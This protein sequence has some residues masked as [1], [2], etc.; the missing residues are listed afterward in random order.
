MLQKI[1]R[2]PASRFLGL[3]LILSSFAF[4]GSPVFA[5]GVRGSR[6]WPITYTL[7]TTNVTSN[8]ATLNGLISGSDLGNDQVWFEY[9]DNF[10]PGNYSASWPFK[11][12]VQEVSGIN[13]RTVSMQISNLKPD[14]LYYYH[15]KAVNK[16]GQNGYGP[17]IDIS[18]RTLSNRI[19]QPVVA[20][21]NNYNNNTYNTTST[22]NT[23][24]N[25][26][27][28]TTNNNYSESAYITKE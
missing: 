25:T 5:S 28:S 20:T 24:N 11:S 15:I 6:S 27:Y 14:T 21:F 12:G 1:V 3:V 9:G 18:F 7:D 16:Y 10:T 13:Q 22:V 2:I 8:S 26:N 17:G 19:L 23:T 4:A